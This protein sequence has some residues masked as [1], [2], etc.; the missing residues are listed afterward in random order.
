MATANRYT[1]IDSARY[2][3][4]SLQE[5]MIAPQYMRQQHDAVDTAIATTEAELAKADPLGIHG[6]LV[7]SE[8]QKLYAQLQE[9]ANKLSSEGFNQ[10][11]KS[12]FL[13]L[14]KAYQQSISPTG[15]IG[16]ANQA[17]VAYQTAKDSYIANATKMGYSPDRAAINWEKHEK[18][19]Y[20]DKFDGQNITNI[21]NLYAPN[22]IDAEDKLRGLLKEA[23]LSSSQI[24]EFGSEIKQDELGNYVLNSGSSI[25]TSSNK[26]QLQAAV[27]FVNNQILN[28]NSDVRRSLDHQGKNVNDVLTNISGLSG[29]YAKDS[30]AK[31]TKSQVTNFS[32]A[33]DLGVAGYEGKLQYETEEAENIQIYDSTLTDGLDSVLSDESFAASAEYESDGSPGLNMSGSS[34]VGKRDK[35]KKTL[36]NTLKPKQLKAYE[37]TVDKLK[38]RHPELRD[39]DYNHPDVIAFASQYIKNNQNILRQ[40]KIITDDFVKS[41]GDRSSG[42]D[43]TNPEK[44]MKLIF[45]E[46]HNR[47]FDIDGKVYTYDDLPDEIRSNFKNLVYSGYYSP[48][49]FMESPNGDFNYE[50]L[51]VS[52]I[53]LTYVDEDTGDRTKVLVSRGASEM[54]DPAFE[55]DKTYKEIF[56]NTNKYPNIPF[57]VPK[58]NISVIY[59][60]SAVKPYLINRKDANGNYAGD[61]I[62][63]RASELQ[64][65]ILELEG[66]TPTNLKK[67]K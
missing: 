57:N 5:L 36:K 19:N 12:D 48:E 55:A 42:V 44:I 15:I 10:S 1:N 33:T 63:A 21:D 16:K 52:P 23:G 11:A 7:N 40:N 53:A 34:F 29:V 9:Q 20:L 31:D 58:S 62:E 6:E 60:P 47:T 17:K 37:D 3:P 43:G 41:Y 38:T 50:N 67:K 18:E 28:E 27:D 32:P 65:K 13:R 4:M 30:Y 59:N 45:N 61:P 66:A 64:S 24:S 56:V 26:N 35:V 49:N 46:A 22:Y 54:A 2:N 14:N 25:A 8:Q 51:Y 39:L